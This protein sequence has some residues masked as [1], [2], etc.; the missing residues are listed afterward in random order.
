MASVQ[1]DYCF[2]E[3]RKGKSGRKGPG[4]LIVDGKYKFRINQ[5]NKAGDKFKMYCVKHGHPQ[6]S[7]K[8]KAVVVKREDESFFLFSADSE[9]THLPDPALV[10]AEELKERMVEIVKKSP[11]DPVTQAIKEVKLQFA[12]ENEDDTFFNEVMESL[13]NQR[14]IE[15]RLLRTRYAIIG[16]MPKNRSEFEP[17]K[18]IKRVL[19]SSKMITL[20]SNN[21]DENWRSIIDRRNPETQYDWEKLSDEMRSFEDEDETE[22]DIVGEEPNDSATHGE[23]SE[24]F[25][26]DCETE[27][28]KDLPK[29]VL[30]YSSIKLLKLF[31]M[32]TRGSVDGTFKSSCKIWKQQFIFMLKYKGHWIPCVWGWL[33]DKSET[34]Y[35][36][37]LHLIQSKLKELHIPFN[38]EEV[39]SDFE[40][41]IHKSLDEMCPGVKILGC[42]FHFAL[43]LQRKVDKGGM[44]TTYEDDPNFR[45]FIKQ[46]I[47]ISSLPLDDIQRGIDWLDQNYQFT[48][49][50][51]ALFKTN[52]MKYI[53]TY[54]R[55]GCY[56]PYVWSPWS[57]SDDYT[58]NNQE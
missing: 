50:K 31:G 15:Q 2:H 35:K 52:F 13:G 20:D 49:E 27:S 47:A 57:R 38:V 56:P 30:A 3:G 40:L 10:K 12:K 26:D 55:D 25:D 29:R 33:P 21:L 44:K 18:F 53:I 34:S 36:V 22:E 19:K 6:F 39:I 1:V 8:A 24:G 4:I 28:V 16:P 54:W 41:N 7:C 37:F 58:N 45:K 17:N 46:A 14:A 43:A 23:S 42:F 48:T 5:V 51:N 9:H 11:C 32:C